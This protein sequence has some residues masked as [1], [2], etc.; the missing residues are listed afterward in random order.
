MPPASTTCDE[1]AGGSCVDGQDPVRSLAQPGLAT[2]GFAGHGWA[3]DGQRPHDGQRAPRHRAARPWFTAPALRVIHD[4]LAQL[5][6]Y[7]GADPAALASA[8]LR[9]VLHTAP[10]AVALVGLRTPTRPGRPRR[11]LRC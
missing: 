7:F 9:Y 4:A 2:F 8:A 3:S 10:H 5:R 11:S 1:V 6:R